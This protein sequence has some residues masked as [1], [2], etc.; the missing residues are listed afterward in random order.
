MSVKNLTF[1]LGAPFLIGNAY[2]GLIDPVPHPQREMRDWVYG[3][4]KPEFDS[5][6]PED[7]IYDRFDEW[8][9][10]RRSRLEAQFGEALKK[11]RLGDWENA[12]QL[13]RAL[14]KD[15]PRYWPATEQLARVYLFLGK[16]RE[17]IELLR[18]VMTWK[19]G[20]PQ[21][22]LIDRINLYGRQFVK[23]ETF[24]EYQ[25]GLNAFL[26][27][28]VKSSIDHFNESLKKEKD[29]LKVLIR[30]GQAF[31]LLE[32]YSE[33]IRILRNAKKL[34]PYER[35][36]SVWLARAYMKSGRIQVGFEEF[37]RAGIYLQSHEQGVVWYADALVE[38]GQLERAISYLRANFRKN[39]FHLKVAEK[40]SSLLG[41]SQN[42]SEKIL[43]ARRTLQIILSRF[44]DYKRRLREKPTFEISRIPFRSEKFR[45]KVHTAISAMDSK[46]DFARK[47]SA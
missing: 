10:P 12:E 44:E 24:Q 36:V 6:S 40:L 41:E 39:P 7:L 19:K 23:N 2:A 38:S 37:S 5:F 22:S 1:I 45:R 34:N 8:P 18:S 43:E 42:D 11:V 47:D 3:S 25:K 9:S 4:E 46:L 31:C 16:R 13:L 17:S 20:K 30:M 32:E 21:I 29:H 14:V 26:N 28:E 35:E 33:A 15:Y 27:G